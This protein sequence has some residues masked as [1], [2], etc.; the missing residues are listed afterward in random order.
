MPSTDDSQQALSRKKSNLATAFKIAGLEPARVR[1]MEILYTF[2][3]VADDIVDEPGRT[4]EGKRAEIDRWRTSIRGIFAAPGGAPPHDT[5]AVELAGIVRDYHIPIEPL[6]E[7]LDGCEMDIGGCEYATAADLRK[8]CHGVACAVGLASIRVFGCVSPQSEAFA[9][10]LGYALQFTNILRDVVEDYCELGRVYLPREE[11]SAFGVNPEDLAR[12]DANPACTRLFRLQ[13]FR[14]KHYFNKARRLIAPEDFA[15]LK[16]ARLMGA[17]YEEILEKIK[18]HGF[19][20]TRERVSLSKWEKILALRLVL[21]QRVPV[22]TVPPRHLLIVGAGVAG[23]AAAAEA[24]LNGDTVTL[25][26]AR[27]VPGGRAGSIPGVAGGPEI[28][29]GHHAVFGC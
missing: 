7:I 25:L 14:A 29:C 3:R 28:D 8:Y 22:A 9:E 18:A 16:A 6:L 4:D 24:A 26:E 1:A 13:Y 17:F 2:C 23:I 12:P 5:L 11:M 10:A 27:P 21:A 15:A 20:L 19:R